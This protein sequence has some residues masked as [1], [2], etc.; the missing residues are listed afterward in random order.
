[1]LENLSIPEDAQ[2]LS[3]EVLGNP[4]YA[5]R[6]MSFLSVW[7]VSL[8]PDEWLVILRLRFSI[9]PWD[10]CW[11]AVTKRVAVTQAVEAA[12]D[13]SQGTL[14][15]ALT[16]W[17]ASEAAPD[18]WPRLRDLLTRDD[19]TLPSG[20]Q[21]S[22][23]TA[24]LVAISTPQMLDSLTRA[25]IL[26]SLVKLPPEMCPVHQPFI[27]DGLTDYSGSRLFDGV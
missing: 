20:D 4:R 10:K 5:I 14:S 2:A 8:V 19:A 21:G 17:A 6:V 27:Y 9:S 16:A 1:M 25:A 7:D 3:D 15:E 23:V 12:P 22:D 24:T 11:P 18:E 26:G 13:A